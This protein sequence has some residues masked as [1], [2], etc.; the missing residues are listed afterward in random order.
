M[1]QLHVI[2]EG[3]TAQIVALSPE[4][5]AKVFYDHVPGHAIEHEYII[6][7]IISDLGLPVPFV[8]HAEQISEKRALIYERINGSTVTSLFSSH[9]WQAIHLLR[10]MAKIQVSVHEK[11][12][13]SLPA[14]RDV[15]LRKIESVHELNNDG[16]RKIYQHL[17][18]LPDGESLCHGDFHPDNILLSKKGPIIIDWADATRGNRIADL[19]RTLLILHFGGL[20]EDPSSL[21][22]R[23]I[24]Y[25]RKLLANYYK[26]SYNRHY[27]FSEDSLRKWMLPIA[28]ARLSEKLPQHEKKQLVYLVQ[29]LLKG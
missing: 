17:E 9:P 3:S 19:A 6:G 5:A 4:K 11:K 22:F 15:L 2:G 8:Y 18:K 23:T 24:L 12:L 29:T 25:V 28:A 10:R 16:K 27:A 26:N 20:S 1:K 14:Q 13:S 7:K 21:K